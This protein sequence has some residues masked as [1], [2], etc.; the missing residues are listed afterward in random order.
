[1]SETKISSPT[2]KTT[3]K[4]ILRQTM[5]VTDPHAENIIERIPL[6]IF[7]YQH[8]RNVTNIKSTYHTNI[9]RANMIPILPK[10]F[11]RKNITACGSLPV[12]GRYV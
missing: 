11:L 8:P 3:C 12:V 10:H 2:W 7:H 5:L 1:M 9:A 6:S 4:I